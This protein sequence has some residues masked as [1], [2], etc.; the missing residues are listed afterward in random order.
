MICR[1]CGGEVVWM[2][3]IEYPHGC[4]MTAMLTSSCACRPSSSADDV[5]MPAAGTGRISEIFGRHSDQCRPTPE[6][7]PLAVRPVAP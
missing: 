2:G 4:L 6:L 5:P 1:K 3:S 7:R